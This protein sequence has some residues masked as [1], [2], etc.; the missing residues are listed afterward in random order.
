[1]RTTALGK[2]SRR[3]PQSVVVEVRERLYEAIFD[4]AGEPAEIRMER[5]ARYTTGKRYWVRCWTP[6][7]QLGERNNA[8]LARAR[9]ILQGRASI[10]FLISTSAAFAF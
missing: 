6:E 7:R 9:A 1:M 5:W 4:E 2:R 3:E 8:V 10:V